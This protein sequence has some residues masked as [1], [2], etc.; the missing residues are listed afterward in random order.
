[1][2]AKLDHRSRPAP[3]ATTRFVGDLLQDL[4][5]SFGPHPYRREDP[6]PCLIG[7]ILAQATNDVLADRAYRVLRRRFPT[8]A[9]V[10]AA[11]RRDVERAIQ[12]CGL[13]RQ[14][15][16]A[17]QAFLRHLMSSRGRLSLADLRRP[18]L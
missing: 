1:M 10:L 2:K 4:E 13:A 5:W 15:A 18:G 17:I 16:G 14:K 8:W 7:T 6:L 11:P 3:N 12:S 9:E